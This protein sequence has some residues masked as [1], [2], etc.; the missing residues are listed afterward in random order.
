MMWIYEENE[1]VSVPTQT[2][3]QWL[4]DE[5]NEKYF[6]GMLPSEL[7]IIVSSR[8][9]NAWGL[10]GWECKNGEL[11]PS[12]IKISSRRAISEFALKSTMLHEMVHILDYVMHPE[13]FIKQTPR[14]IVKVRY[15]A[16]G[17]WFMNNPASKAI[18]KD[19]F[20]IERYVQDS[21]EES[22]ELSDKYKELAKKKAE[23]GVYAIIGRFARDPR[24]TFFRK[25]TIGEFFVYNR[26]DSFEN[27]FENW[28][29]CGAIEFMLVKTT[30]EKIALARRTKSMYPVEMN[31]DEECKVFKD[32]R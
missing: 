20:V 18:R 32:L 5:C 24:K 25:I 23:E 26:G 2:E 22:S 27:E 14:G 31:I 4:Y 17:D 21:Q 28:K 9:S 16:H 13:H 12:Y 19:G 7:P 29:E 3:C 8:M 6:A 15:N 30:N 1:K 11:H 10:A